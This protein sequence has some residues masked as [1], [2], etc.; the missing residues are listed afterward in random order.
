M[1]FSGFVAF[2]LVRVLKVVT[3]V[4]MTFEIYA[5]CVIPISAFF[6]SSLCVCYVHY[7]TL[8]SSRLD[9]SVLE[10]GKLSSSA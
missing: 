6:A 5:T 9:C 10:L 4:K 8:I 3:P 2:I 1:G 7:L